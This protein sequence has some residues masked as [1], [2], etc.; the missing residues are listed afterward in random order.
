MASINVH[1]LGDGL[2]KFKILDL[3]IN[4]KINRSR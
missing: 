1:I 4:Q 3:Q 2:T